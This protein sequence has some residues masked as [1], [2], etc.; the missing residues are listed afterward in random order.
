MLRNLH[1]WS[2]VHTMKKLVVEMRWHIIKYEIY[3]Q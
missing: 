2:T 1:S 3:S